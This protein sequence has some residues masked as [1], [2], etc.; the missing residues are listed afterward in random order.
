M[1]TTSSE[2]PMA[3]RSDTDVPSHW[4]LARLGKRVLRPGGVELTTKLLQHA[5][6]SGADVVELAPGLG[7]TAVDIAAHSPLSY[8]GVD[9]DPD[10]VNTVR[11][12]V[13]EHAVVVVAD[14]AETGLPSESADVV[15]GEAMLTMQGD[16]GKRAIV[17]EAA[18][19]LRPG[20][21]YAIHELCL[22]P[23]DLADE[24][25]T[26]LR[27]ALAKTMKVNARPQTTAEWRALLED[28]GLVIDYI[29]TSPMA[30]LQARRVI[31]DEGFAGTARFARNLI[32]HP[33]ARRRVLAMRATFLKNKRSLVAIAIVAH[34][35]AEGEAGTR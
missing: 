5:G 30:L 32:A 3:E 16:K 26:E 1:V 35:P 22:T 10:A 28:C 19:I 25:K 17:A 24:T 11:S 9:S 27:M 13:G 2:L 29:D 20:G 8:T 34:R 33:A 21:R 15:I 12:V 14:A 23:A 4:L 7:R 31:T 18:R 6:I